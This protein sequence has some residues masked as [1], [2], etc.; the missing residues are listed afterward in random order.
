MS[1]FIYLAGTAIFFAL[2]FALIAAF[3]VLPGGRP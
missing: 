3:D 1:D 2:C